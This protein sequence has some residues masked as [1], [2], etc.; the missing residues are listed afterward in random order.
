MVSCVIVY[1]SINNKISLTNPTKL[2]TTKS[3]KALPIGRLFRD[4]DNIPW[5]NFKIS[6]NKKSQ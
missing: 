4:N 1:I 2:S 3:P 6:K 5:Q